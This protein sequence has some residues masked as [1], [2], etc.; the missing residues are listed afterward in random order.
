MTE[1]SQRKGSEESVSARRST[2]IR[3]STKPAFNTPAPAFYRCDHCHRLV[4][5]VQ[6]TSPLSCAS[7]SCC[8][9]P[10]TAL[11]LQ[12]ADSP[13]AAL[14]QPHMKVSG[15]FDANVLSVTVGEPLHPMAVEHH[16]EWIYL[17]TFQGGQLK[18]LK[19]GGK[20]GATFSLADDDAYVYCDRP[21]CKGSRCKFN[22][23]RGFSA[24]CYCSQ[25]GLW[26]CAF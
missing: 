9:A 11:A 25:H 17:Y 24:F 20:P 10:M 3:N 18:F 26:Q 6:P 1:V 22:C 5:A 23:K 19:P 16:L 2:R 4:I 7:F 21:V 12:D 8:G 14:H 15:G 13:L